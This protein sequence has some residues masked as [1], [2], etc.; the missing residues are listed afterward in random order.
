M[1]KIRD[2]CFEILYEFKR[3]AGGGL[4]EGMEP[5]PPMLFSE[6]ELTNMVRVIATRIEGLV[7]D[8][9]LGRIK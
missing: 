3:A 6:G 4:L 1:S 7:A 9:A 8:S 5:P 2:L